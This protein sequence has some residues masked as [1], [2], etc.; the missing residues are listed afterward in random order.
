L[1]A[2]YRKLPVGSNAIPKGCCPVAMGL[3]AA[4]KVPLLNLNA[5]TLF[6]PT[7]VTY[8]NLAAGWMVSRRGC[9]GLLWQEIPQ[10]VC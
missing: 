10:L 5:N 7:P 2:T 8:A 3:A 4:V 9:R 1:F 6:S